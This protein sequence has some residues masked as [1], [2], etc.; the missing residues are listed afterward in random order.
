M[1]ALN[2]LKVKRG[3][4]MKTILYF[5]LSVI[6]IVY[7]LC[8]AYL[9]INPEVAGTIGTILGYVA[10]YGGLVIILAFAAINFFG[11]PFKIAFFILLV[12]VAILY[13]VT[14]IIPGPFQSLFGIITG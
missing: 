5:V 12:V 2:H 11:N 7:L 1:S 13:I 9:N 10:K 4:F 14:A 8:L 6:S 3:E